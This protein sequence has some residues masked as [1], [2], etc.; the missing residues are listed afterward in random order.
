MLAQARIHRAAGVL[1][2]AKRAR[3]AQWML[4][5]ASMTGEVVENALSTGLFAPF[6]LIR[7]GI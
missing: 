2:A 4:A 1:L 3:A 5:C 7:M 6:P